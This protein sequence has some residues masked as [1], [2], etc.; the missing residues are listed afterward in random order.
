MLLCCLVRWD[1]K[2]R[3]VLAIH[4]FD[5]IGIK[6]SCHSTKGGFVIAGVD[7]SWLRSHHITHLLISDLWLQCTMN[8]STLTNFS[9]PWTC[10]RSL[11]VSWISYPGSS[12]VWDYHTTQLLIRN[13]Y[14]YTTPIYYKWPWPWLIFS[15]LDMSAFSKCFY[16]SSIAHLS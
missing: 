11:N 5:L 4:A 10:L 8:D 9:A 14:R 2:P 15:T 7:K 12:W 6:R 16:S 13:Y 1:F 3:S